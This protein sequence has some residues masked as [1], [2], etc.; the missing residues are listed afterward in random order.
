MRRRLLVAAVLLAACASGDSTTTTTSS[1]N[2]VSLGWDGHV[3]LV[4]FPD[5]TRC[6]V[7]SAGDHGGIDC[8]WPDR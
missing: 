2:R 4:T 1:P 3:Q 7:L 8:D 6:V 5:G